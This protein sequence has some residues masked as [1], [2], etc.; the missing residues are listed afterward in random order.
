MRKWAA[1]GLLF[2]L[3]EMNSVSAPP[4]PTAVTP[5]ASGRADAPVVQILHRTARGEGGKLLDVAPAALVDASLLALVPEAD[6]A[7]DGLIG[8]MGKRRPVAWIAAPDSGP[9]AEALA[10]R[11][12]LAFPQP[13]QVRG[14]ALPWA[15]AEKSGSRAAV[16]VW[17]P[18]WKGGR[19]V[20][21]L[22]PLV[23][24]LKSKGWTI[25]WVLVDLLEPKVEGIPWP[26]DEV[27]ASRDPGNVAAALEILLAKK[28]RGGAEGS[29]QAS[30][31]LEG[32]KPTF[33][34]LRQ[35][36]AP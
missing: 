1:L 23:S 30:E 6:L 15:L 17:R 16:L 3:L 5:R 20:P 28:A 12:K 35:A 14:G 9:L 32:S 8:L 19:A 31:G 29:T 18:E 7:L 27:L 22:L 36:I 24:E 26:A 4:P 13:G 34:W 11:M 33:P 21:D 25:R 2:C 10:A